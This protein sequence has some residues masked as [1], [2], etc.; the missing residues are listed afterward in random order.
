MNTEGRKGIPRQKGRVA[1][2][3]K[4]FGRDG[5]VSDTQKAEKLSQRTESN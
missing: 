2:Q 5:Q 3:I 4:I 1:L